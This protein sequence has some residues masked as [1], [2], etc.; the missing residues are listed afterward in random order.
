MVVIGPQPQDSSHL[1]Q[2]GHADL[3]RSKIVEPFALNVQK[4]QHKTYL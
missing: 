1:E 4:N 2:R 3:H